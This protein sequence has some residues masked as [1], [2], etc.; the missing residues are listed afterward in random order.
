MPNSCKII[1]QKLFMLRPDEFATLK[2]IL[3]VDAH[4]MIQANRLDIAR[5]ELLREVDPASKVLIGRPP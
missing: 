4:L 3:A 5:V 1:M 2:L